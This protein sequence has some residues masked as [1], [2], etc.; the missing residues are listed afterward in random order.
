MIGVILG[1]LEEFS[2]DDVEKR[3]AL[4]TIESMMHHDRLNHL[5]II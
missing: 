3:Q 1:I 5:R 4:C 2:A